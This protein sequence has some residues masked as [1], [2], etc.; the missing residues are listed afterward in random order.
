MN[1]ETSTDASRIFFIDSRDGTNESSNPQITTDFSLNLEDPIVVPNHHTILMS[2]HRANIPRT[3]YN[4]K[5]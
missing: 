3:F 1:F 5:N 2:L 4:F